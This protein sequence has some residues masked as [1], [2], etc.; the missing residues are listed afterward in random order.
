MV[1]V[2]SLMKLIGRFLTSQ[3]TSGRAALT[4]VTVAGA[5]PALL[6]SGDPLTKIFFVYLGVRLTMVITEAMRVALTGLAIRLIDRSGRPPQP[7]SIQVLR[8]LLNRRP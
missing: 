6:L 3:R 4:G 2:A 1:L 5:Y 7:R 8:L